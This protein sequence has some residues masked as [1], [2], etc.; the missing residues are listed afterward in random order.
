ML[1]ECGRSALCVLSRRTK[2]GVAHA[3][4]AAGVSLE[5]RC[6]ADAVASN[7]S[8]VVAGVTA[9]RRPLRLLHAEALKSRLH[10]AQLTSR[11]VG[12]TRIEL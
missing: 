4:R 3:D 5:R 6:R 9:V 2:T 8:R 10:R 7:K 1:P 11:L 12:L